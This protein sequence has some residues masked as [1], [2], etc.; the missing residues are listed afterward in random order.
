MTPAAAIAIT[1]GSMLVAA[2][3]MPVVI[4]LFVPGVMEIL[5]EELDNLRTYFSPTPIRKIQTESR[6][7]AD[8]G[9]VIGGGLIMIIGLLLLLLDR[10]GRP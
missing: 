4:R 3:F 5:L 7:C 9:L 6:T 1:F 8:I 2:G 10:A